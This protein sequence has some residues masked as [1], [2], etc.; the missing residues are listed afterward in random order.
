[1]DLTFQVPMQDCSLQHQT[2]LSPAD[3]YTTESHFCFGPASSFF[4]ELFAIA[5]CSSPVAYFEHF[6]PGGAHLP[7]SYFLP[8][9]TVHGVLAARILEGFFLPSPP[10]VDHIL[11][12]LFI[13][14]H[15]SWVALHGIAHSFIEL[16][17]LLHHDKAVI[18]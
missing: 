10:P 12:E 16:C 11:S 8:F 6:R 18:H 4:L 2:L 1:M 5:L 9:Y 17:K 7:V 14:T 15:L 3:T 13:M